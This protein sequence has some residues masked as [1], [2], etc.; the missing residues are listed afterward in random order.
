MLGHCAQ[1]LIVDQELKAFD[2]LSY[3]LRWTK[4]QPQHETGTK[5]S[6]I[7]RQSLA[8]LDDAANRM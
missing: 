5:N 6:Q 2:D 1:A 3:Q 8:F 7:D 4:L